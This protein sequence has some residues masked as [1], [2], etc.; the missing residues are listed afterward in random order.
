MSRVFIC[1]ILFFISFNLS[2]Q[3]RNDSAQAYSYKWHFNV[4][5]QDGYGIF[6]GIHSVGVEANKPA[7]TGYDIGLTKTSH[8][9][10]EDGIMYYEKYVAFTYEN[11]SKPVY[12]LGV[13]AD[14][15]AIFFDFGLSLNSLSTFNDSYRISVTPSL[16]VSAF[17]FFNF[18]LNVAYDIVPV[19]HQ[20]DLFNHWKTVIRLSFGVIEKKHRTQT[21]QKL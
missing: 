13:G 2:A 12:G 10:G 20:F 19:N 17:Y 1:F 6:M 11:L 8:D 16:G 15:K 21:S 3:N 5:P 7:Q 18:D 9:W 14:M 4:K